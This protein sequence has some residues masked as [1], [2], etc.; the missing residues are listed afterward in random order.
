V[1]SE[2]STIP[3]IPRTASATPNYFNPGKILGDTLHKVETVPK[4]DT[5]P[6]GR[7]T[8]RFTGGGGGTSISS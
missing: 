7:G 5:F 2:S 1:P 4:R 6:E 8:V 3:T